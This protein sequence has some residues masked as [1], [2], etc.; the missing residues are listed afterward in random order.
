MAKFTISL[1]DDAIKMFEKHTE[2]MNQWCIKNGHTPDWNI[3]KSIRCRAVLS[4]EQF[5]KEELS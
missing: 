2:I 1:E 3:E 4:V 5:L